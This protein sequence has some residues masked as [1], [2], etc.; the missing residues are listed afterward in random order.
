MARLRQK[1][2][3]ADNYELD[4]PGL[5]FI[6]INVDPTEASIGRC[7]DLPLDLK[8]SKSVL[9][10]QNC[11]YNCLYLAIYYRGHIQL[12]TTPHVKVIMQVN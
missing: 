6:Q 1:I 12:K 7:Q 4:F 11:N 10:I 9:N 5:K 2:Y 3:E 8:N